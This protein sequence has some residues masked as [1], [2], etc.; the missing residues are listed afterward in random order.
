MPRFRLAAHP[1]E[2]KSNHEVA[3]LRTYDSHEAALPNLFDL[4]VGRLRRATY[5][6]DLFLL[7]M[8]P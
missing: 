8:E 6:A 5:Q 1:D 7:H 4:S 3:R 2:E